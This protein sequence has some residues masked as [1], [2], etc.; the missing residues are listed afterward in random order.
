MYCWCDRR[1]GWGSDWRRVPGDV[2]RVL[3]NE[4]WN[5]SFQNKI[6]HRL[7]LQINNSAFRIP[8]ALNTLALNAGFVC[9]WLKFSDLVIF[10]GWVSDLISFWCV[11]FNAS[12]FWWFL[13]G[14]YIYRGKMFLKISFYVHVY[15]KF[16]IIWAI[17]ITGNVKN[18]NNYELQTHVCLSVC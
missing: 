1:N 16:S 7:K 10:C 5:A 9:A 14:D 8:L 11:G 3:E 17:S 12:V 6:F 13:K 4:Y 15:W 2:P 18:I